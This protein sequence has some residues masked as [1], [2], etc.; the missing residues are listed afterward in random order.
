MGG[1]WRMGKKPVLACR[2]LTED[3][4]PRFLTL[5]ALVLQSNGRRRPMGKQTDVSLPAGRQAEAMARFGL[6][7]RLEDDVPLA[8]AA[9]DAGVPIRTA[10]RWRARFRQN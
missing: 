8:R 3:G 4:L 2:F 10:R 5:R 6:R 7:P 9:R 1:S